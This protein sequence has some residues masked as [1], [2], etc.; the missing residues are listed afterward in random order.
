MALTG[1]TRT[2]Y[3]PV[4]SSL[5]PQDNNSVLLLSALL[6]W[7]S[8]FRNSAFNERTHIGQFAVHLNLSIEQIR[9]SLHDIKKLEILNEK[10]ELIETQKD[11]KDGNQNPSNKIKENILLSINY[12]KLSELLK[13]HNIN[14]S[15][16]VLKHSADDSF[17]FFATIGDYALPLE[18]KLIGCAKDKIF[19][20]VAYAL[21]KLLVYIANFEEDFAFK[22]LAPGWRMLIQPP[23]T[24]KDIASRWLSEDDRAIDIEFSDGTFFLPDGD[25]YG[26]QEHICLQRGKKEE[27]KIL[28]SAFLL[29]AQAA[30]KNQL[31]FISD[32]DPKNIEKAIRL[33]HKALNVKVELLDL[34]YKEFI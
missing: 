10:R 2:P 24:Y 16:K 29:T 5:L 19:A 20:D 6:Y 25:K 3:Y 27:P 32:L 17:D 18:Q 30:S 7:C 9:K 8:R 28:A 34:Y 31:R 21:S 33:V 12:K 23:A 1:L 14:L 26:A 22:A 11:P 4:L 13:E 15:P